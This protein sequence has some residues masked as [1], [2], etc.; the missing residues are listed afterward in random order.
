MNWINIAESTTATLIAG[1]VT[2]LAGGVYAVVKIKPTLRKSN[3]ENW[4]EAS[5]SH[6]GDISGSNNQI[7]SRAGDGPTAQISGDNNQLDQSTTTITHTTYS[8]ST[9][10]PSEESKGLLIALVITFLV[11][12]LFLISWPIVNAVMA[13]ALVYVAV[14]SLSIIIASRRSKHTSDMAAGRFLY[15]PLVTIIFS[16][17]MSLALLRMNI[18][19]NQWSFTSIRNR[20]WEKLDITHTQHISIAKVVT[21][22]IDLYGLQGT[23][24]I[25]LYL[26]AVIMIFLGLYTA[27][28]VNVKSYT[29]LY[30]RKPITLDRKKFRRDLLLIGTVTVIGSFLTYD[31]AIT[32][33]LNVYISQIGTS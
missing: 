31:W 5:T 29:M 28:T 24:A 7:L 11:S 18:P 25:L 15:F 2:A 14:F 1:G 17:L 30:H 3:K 23:S 16:I 26:I 20:I 21:T 22:V 9:S 27:F 32:W 8:S 13:V 10:K 12:V 4:G 6:I 19:G 33:I